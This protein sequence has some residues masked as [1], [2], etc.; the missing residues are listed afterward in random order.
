MR[1]DA[2]AHVLHSL[3]SA[4]KADV[5]YTAVQFVYGTIIR[6]PEHFNFFAEYGSKL[7]RDQGYKRRAFSQICFHSPVVN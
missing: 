3:R 7:L 6:L 5:I 2:L 4:V 1:N